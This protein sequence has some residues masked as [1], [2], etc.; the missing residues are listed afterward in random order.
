[1]L[2]AGQKHALKTEVN[3]LNRHLRIILQNHDYSGDMIPASPDC[4]ILQNEYFKELLVQRQMLWKVLG[5]LDL[6]F[7]EGFKLL[8]RPL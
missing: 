4:E 6:H 8:P 2:T 7:E 1:M 5:I 3:R